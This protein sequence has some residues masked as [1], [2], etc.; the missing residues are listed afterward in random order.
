VIPQD[1]APGQGAKGAVDAKQTAEENGM[2]RNPRLHVRRWNRKPNGANFLQ[3][4]P[5][6]E[7]S[8]YLTYRW[9]L[10]FDWNATNLG[11]GV[12]TATPEGLLPL[13]LKAEVE[14]LREARTR[15]QAKQHVAARP[16]KSSK[17][18]GNVAEIRNAVEAG[19]VREHSVKRRAIG[20]LVDVLAG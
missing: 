18:I 7:S 14:D 12:A 8:L 13:E 17:L 15:A 3:S 16:Y 1:A 10:N 4:E 6:R 9:I 20:Y 5:R 2:P 11:A 19:K